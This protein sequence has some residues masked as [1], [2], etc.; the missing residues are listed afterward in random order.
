[1]PNQFKNAIIIPSYKE[2]LALPKLLNELSKSLDAYDIVLVVDDS[3]KEISDHLKQTCHDSLAASSCH[4]MFI[5]NEV[6]KG[7]GAAVR[8][9]MQS[10]LTLYPTLEYVLE[11]D[12]DGSHT[13]SDIVSVL[14]NNTDC[15]LIVGSRYVDGSKIE[16]WPLSRR[17]FSWILNKTIPRVTQVPLNDIT[18][19]LRRYSTKAVSEI[20]KNP[21]RNQGFIYLTE[22]AILVDRA[23]LSVAEIPITFIDRTLGQ[24]TV[25]WREI[26]RSFVGVFKIIFNTN[27]R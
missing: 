12:A 1:M 9:G 13:P 25:T 3:P 7:R 24:S 14:R 8:K 18:N 4:Y 15:D 20:L 11:C 22:Q 19:G 16:G 27:I 5:Q 10:V 21:Q 2:T 23:L 6:K 17:I 26:L